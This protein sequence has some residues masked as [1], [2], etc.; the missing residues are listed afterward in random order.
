MNDPGLLRMEADPER[1]AQEPVRQGEGSFGL[2][3]RLADDDEVVRPPRQPIAG[4]GHGTIER[5]EEDVRPQRARD[6][7]LRDPRRGRMPFPGLDHPCIEKAPDQVQNTPIADLGR[8]Q[9]HQLVLVDL[10]KESTDV[11]I[12]DPEVAFVDLL[13]HLP[14]RHVGRTHRPIP[15]RAVGKV[16]FED[17]SHLLNQRLL[18]HP[19]RDRGD[20][21]FSE[22]SVRLRDADPLHR[23]GSV[24]PVAQRPVQRGQA[25]L[26][27][28]GEG[29][30]GEAVDAG[31]ALVVS[32]VSPGFGQ[33]GRSIDL[34]D[35]RMDFP[36][37]WI[38]RSPSVSGRR[39]GLL[40]AGAGS[41]A[42]R[43]C[44]HFR[45]VLT[46]S[47]RVDA[48]TQH[49]A[50]PLRSV[51]WI[52]PASLLVRQRSG[53]FCSDP[54]PECRV[55]GGRAFALPPSAR[56]NGSCVF[57]ASRFPVWSSPLTGDDDPP[58]SPGGLRGSSMPAQRLSL[59]EPVPPPAMYSPARPAAPLPHST[60]PS[61]SGRSFGSDRRRRSS[62]GDPG[63]FALT[64]FLSTSPRSDSWH[65]FGRTFAC[66]YIRPYHRGLQAGLCVACFSPFR[67]RVSHDSSHTFPMDDTRPPWVTDALPHRVARTHLGATGWNPCA[68]APRVRARPFPVFGRPVHRSGSLP[69]ITT[70]WFSSS[71]SDPASRR[72]ACP[73]EP[74]R[75]WRPGAHFL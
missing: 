26:L 74:R 42:L 66:A 29:G 17:G 49:G 23:S 64:P 45:H 7:A 2:L 13:P 38:L 50:F 43:T 58:A 54:V 46:R 28:V 60:G 37:S 10:V 15:E 53:A 59:C 72:A 70:R 41:F 75:L 62:G 27:P 9:A 30:D 16:G 51:F 67:L 73:P 25:L 47:S 34:V 18:N 31:P 48:A 1:L 32:D 20:S 61:P 11:G 35:Q 8:D 36:L 19:I 22:P 3:T 21:E 55:G 14:H 4:L 68:F 63:P 44:P 56:S 40:D 33:V 57:P 69:L 39:A 6:P 5:R 24:A 71:L 12:Q 65:R 52:R